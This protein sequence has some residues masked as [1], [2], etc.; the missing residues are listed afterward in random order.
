MSGYGGY[1]YDF[2]KWTFKNNIVDGSITKNTINIT[3]SK[4]IDSPFL[5]KYPYILSKMKIQVNGITDGQSIIFSTDGGSKPVIETISKDG[6]YEID[7]TKLNNLTPCIYTRFIGECNITI[8]QIPL[9]PNALVL[10]G[11]DDYV[12]LE[13]ELEAFKTIIIKCIQ[14][15]ENINKQNWNYVYDS[16]AP[17]STETTN[18]GYLGYDARNILQTNGKLTR[19]S[20]ECICV[21]FKPSLFTESLKIITIGCRNTKNEF[22]NIALYKFLGFKEELTEEQ[23]QAII[24]KYNLLDGVDEIEVS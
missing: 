3:N 21:K 12:S 23:I 1:N 9:Y 16:I 15:S 4:N 20:N 24:K 18:R 5:Y 14:V 7:W 22:G 17:N 19:I 10:D 8:E 6:I 11:V 2:T 13:K